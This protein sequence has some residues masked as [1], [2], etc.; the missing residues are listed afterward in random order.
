MNLKSSNPIIIYQVKEMAIIGL[1]YLALI[2]RE[3]VS[4]IVFG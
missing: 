2:L 3:V 1:Q 4:N